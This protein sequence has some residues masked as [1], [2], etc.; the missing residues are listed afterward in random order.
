MPVTMVT[1]TGLLPGESHGFRVRA[2]NFAGL[3]S[4]SNRITYIP[5]PRGENVYGTAVKCQQCTTLH[6]LSIRI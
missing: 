3:S 2:G 4:P 5:A 6:G 1:L